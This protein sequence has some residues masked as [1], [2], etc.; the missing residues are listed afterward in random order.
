M[1]SE[2]KKRKT[3]MVMDKRQN[4]HDIQKLELMM[5]QYI[6]IYIYIVDKKLSNSWVT[7]LGVARIQFILFFS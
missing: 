7:A 3:N 2:E 4:R 1:H 5:L 6:Y